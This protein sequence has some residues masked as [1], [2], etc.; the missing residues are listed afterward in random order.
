MI[1]RLTDP[2]FQKFHFRGQY[3]IFFS[4][5]MGLFWIFDAEKMIGLGDCCIQDADAGKDC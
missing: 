2:T 4:L 1:F 3:N 5:N